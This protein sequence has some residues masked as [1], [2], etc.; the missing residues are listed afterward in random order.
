MSDLFG[1]EGTVLL[2]RSRLPAPYA[3][4]VASLRRLLEDLEIEV[5]LFTN[6]LWGRLRT[7]PG[8]TAA[9]IPG[10]GLVLGAVF[11][12][13]V[14]D[15]SRFATAPQLACWAGADTRSTTR[16]TPT[17]AVARSPSRAA[18]GWGGGPRWSRSRPSGHGRTRVGALRDRAPSAAGGTSAR[19]PPPGDRLSTSL[20]AA[21]RPRPG[22]CSTHPGSRHEV[23]S[24]NLWSVARSCRS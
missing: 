14:G 12:V 9:A 18:P 4:R 24:H 2:D 15:V 23:V 1:I 5:D 22:P 17:C 20:R 16:P 13:E 10:I 19:S 8:Y 11:L 7:E 21:R 3:A 6:L